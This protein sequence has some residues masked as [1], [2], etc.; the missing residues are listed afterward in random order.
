MKSDRARALEKQV[1]ALE[2]QNKQLQSRLDLQ[3]KERAVN[4]ILTSIN[5]T[6][7]ND[8]CYINGLILHSE[9]EMQ[10]GEVKSMMLYDQSLKTCINP[11]SWVQRNK[12][13][14]PKEEQ[15][16]SQKENFYK[17]LFK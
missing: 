16:E 5:H 13:T 4:D 10:E 3:V 8:E 15:K 9:I 12:T 7:A 14:E 1:Q 2:A 6:F 11:D 17:E